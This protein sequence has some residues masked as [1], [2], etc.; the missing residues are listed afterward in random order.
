VSKEHLTEQQKEAIRGVSARDKLN[1]IRPV[2]LLR[3]KSIPRSPY[4]LLKSVFLTH[5]YSLSE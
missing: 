4:L 2:L 3:R 1:R 5:D